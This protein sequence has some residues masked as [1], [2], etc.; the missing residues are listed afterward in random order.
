MDLVPLL[1]AVLFALVANRWAAGAGRRPWVWTVGGLLVV[2]AGLLM[3][4]GLELLA[5]DADVAVWAVPAAGVAV[6]LAAFF[7]ATL[8]VGLRPRVRRALF[9]T[10]GIVAF[11]T[12]FPVAAIGLFAFLF[13]GYCEESYESSCT[14]DWLPLL[15]VGMLAVVAGLFV[16]TAACVRGHR[17][18]RSA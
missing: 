10:A 7:T 8:A 4:R 18:A 6:G 12:A 3:L 14:S 16:L 5:D 1:A 17:R 2:P 15:G 13:T 9:A 11:A